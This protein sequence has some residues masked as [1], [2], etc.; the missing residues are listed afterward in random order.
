M[1]FPALKKPAVLK[2]IKDDEGCK[3]VFKINSFC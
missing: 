2:A 1:L 3:Y